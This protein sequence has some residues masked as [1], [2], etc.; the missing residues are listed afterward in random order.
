MN[1][2]LCRFYSTAASLNQ[3]IPQT[4]L[5]IRTPFT[6]LPLSPMD[7]HNSPLS[8]P[9]TYTS[10]RTTTEKPPSYTLSPD[11]ESQSQQT[12]WS[13]PQSPPTHIP[14]IP[15]WP[16]QSQPTTMVVTVKH[17]QRRRLVAAARSTTT[18]RRPRKAVAYCMLLGFVVAA[19]FIVMVIVEVVARVD[20][21]V[22]SH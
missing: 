9:P 20:A 17:T 19:V 12:P 7:S 10:A 8:P 22:N 15:Q 14:H 3:D 1:S 4:H 6:H 21:E 18:T 5:R 2:G 11:L 13:N 16:G